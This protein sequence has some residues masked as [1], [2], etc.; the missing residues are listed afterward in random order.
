MDSISIFKPVV[1]CSHYNQSMPKRIQLELQ[2][3]CCFY[4]GKKFVIPDQRNHIGQCSNDHL[5][6]RSQGFKL[7]GNKVLACLTCNNDKANRFPSINDLARYVSLY[8][9]YNP[10]SVEHLVIRTKNQK[11]RF[12]V[13][14]LP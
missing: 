2:N 6:P 9:Q 12:R 5:F 1:R 7:V 4:C 14:Y 13:R 10:K 8:K 3:H 11:P